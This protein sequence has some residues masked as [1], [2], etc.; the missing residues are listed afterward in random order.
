MSPHDQIVKAFMEV[1]RPMRG[2]IRLLGRVSDS[3]IGNSS[4]KEVFFFIPDVHLVSPHRQERF[5]DYGFNHADS[6]L[7]TKLLKKLAALK[8]RWDATGRNK[9]VTVCLGDFFDMWRE[10]PGAAHPEEIDDDEFGDL[11]DL[12]YRG[13]HRNRPCLKATMLLGNHDTKR[14]APLQEI[15]YQLKAFNRSNRNTPF[16]FATHGDAFDQLETLPDAF[17][18]F[19]VYFIGKLT[20]INKYTITNWGKMAAKNN[21]PLSRLDKAINKEKYLLE[22]Q[23]GAVVVEPEKP[24]PRMVARVGRRPS[25]MGYERFG[26]FYKAV[27]E[28]ARQYPTADKLR[29]VAVGHSHH[30][31]MD[32]CRPE[33]GG[34]PLLVLDAG[35]WIENCEYPTAEAGDRIVEPCAQLAVIH[36]NDARLYQISLA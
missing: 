27:K 5:G 2:R 26:D 16:L 8:R 12:L 31:R 36:G 29:V 9:L 1:L 17:Q 24:L 28:A 30:A 7:L 35:A 34:R 19:V 33:D 11:R 23:E 22:P 4:R 15:S 20:P 13:V 18:E 25:D 10:F 14:G 21:K 32:L 6:E 3:V